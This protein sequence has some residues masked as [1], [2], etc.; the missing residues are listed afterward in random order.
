[1]AKGPLTVGRTEHGATG[2]K[3][4]GY[5]AGGSSTPGAS[6]VDRLDFSSD[7]TAAVA[8]GPLTKERNY[9]SA[10]SGGQYALPQ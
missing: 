2:N 7:T 4:F 6:V 9:V 1:M 10:H 8:K 3:D 5:Y